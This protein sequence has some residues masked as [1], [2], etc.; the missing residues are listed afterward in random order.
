M[1]GTHNHS[2]GNL[3][4]RAAMASVSMA[5]FL[6]GLKAFAA[7][8]T[9]SI[10]M[11]GS[12]ADTALDTITSIIT[13]IGVRVAAQPADGNHRFGHG[14]AEALVALVQVTIIIISA[15]S[16]AYTAI[17][18]LIHSEPVTHDAEFGIGVSTFATVLTLALVLYQRRVIK[19]T[20]SVAIQA[21]NV[22]YQADLLVNIAVIVAIVLD[23]YLGWHRADP[24]F[25]LMIALWLVYGAYGASK[26]AIADLMDHE[27]PEAERSA[28]AA[29]AMKH[30]QVHGVHDMRTRSS[31]AHRFAQFHVWVDGRMTV[32]DAH[33]VMDE[34]EEEIA[35]DFPHTEV[36]IHIDPEGHVETGHNRDSGMVRG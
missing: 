2:H 10:A 20:G 4:A 1:S 25:G 19:A 31:G 15:L 26:Q 24:L 13:L 21:D 12:L 35:K 16:I 14:K 6:L 18:N 3:T 36:L 11:L 30:P 34:I 7:L 32:M 17:L 23:Q 8:H 9:G 5:L 33:N 22:H 28:L 27:W 29:I